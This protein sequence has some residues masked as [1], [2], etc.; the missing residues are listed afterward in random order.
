M[1]TAISV[2]M[3]YQVYQVYLICQQREMLVP[4]GGDSVHSP[5]FAQSP[6][7]NRSI[8]VYEHFSPMFRW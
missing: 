2:F 8:E 4:R 6:S 3:V 7:A 1:L 5:V